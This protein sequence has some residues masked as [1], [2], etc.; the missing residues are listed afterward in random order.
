MTVEVKP[1]SEWTD[2]ELIANAEELHCS[3]NTIECYGTKDL[4]WYE[5]I[6]RELEKRGYEISEE[7]SLKINKE[8]DEEK[9]ES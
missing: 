7:R 3:I 6:C 4:L 1:F 5:G 2:K 8:D 9:D